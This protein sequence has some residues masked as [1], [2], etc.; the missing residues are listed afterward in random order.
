MEAVKKSF[1]YCGVMRLLGLNFKGG[2]G[3]TN[4]KKSIARYKL[5]TSHF[6]CQGWSKGRTFSSKATLDDYL[7]GQRGIQSHKLKLLLLKEKVFA[8][9]CSNCK[10]VEWMGVE[11][12]LELDHINGNHED[13]S[14]QNLRL[15]CPNCHALTP[16]YC[17]KNKKKIPVVGVEPT[18]LSD[19]GFEPDA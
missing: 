18:I 13:N 8:K 10:N 14:L 15:L 6:K 5:D 7:N 11:I 12:P 19:T 17:A 4:I 1:S 3:Y 9:V 2:G 16:N